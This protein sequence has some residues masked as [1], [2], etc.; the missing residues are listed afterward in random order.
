[1]KGNDRIFET[2]MI[3]INHPGYTVLKILIFNIII[4]FMPH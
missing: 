3:P 2:T 4:Y 1:M